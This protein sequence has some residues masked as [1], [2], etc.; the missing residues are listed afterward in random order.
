MP[1][2]PWAQVI[3]TFT[4]E[5]NM[6]LWRQL[7]SITK[8]IHAVQGNHFGTTINALSSTWSTAVVDWL[9]TIVWD[10]EEARL[11]ATDV[12]ELLAIVLANRRVLDAIT[13]PR[14]L[15]GDLWTG[16]L[17]VTRGQEGPRIVAV[18][19][20]DRTSWG[21]PL[22]DWTM[23]LLPRHAGTEVEAF[24]ETYGHPEPSLGARVRMLIYQGRYI[25]GIRLEQHRLHRHE[26]V[27][28]TSQEM[29]TILEELRS[30][31]ITQPP[32]R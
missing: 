4:P 9:T 26:A 15:H 11:D 21:D 17:L 29:R 27:K 1:G 3:H 22:A 30:L 13:H 32:K 6:V 10:L 31:P 28:R 5:E 2:E 12:T 18:L 7:G 16:N 25:R 24:W 20:S 19:D 8:T 14:L 23:F